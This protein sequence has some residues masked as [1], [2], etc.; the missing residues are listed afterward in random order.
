MT[1][2]RTLVW[3]LS[4]LFLFAQCSTTDN[5]TD[6]P[7][8]DNTQNEEPTP[9]EPVNEPSVEVELATIETTEITDISENSAK[10]GGAITDD[11][12]AEVTA[13]GVCWST[14]TEPSLENNVT[15]NGNGSG[16]FVAE[17]L[18]LTPNTTYYVRAYA[19]NSEGTAYG[20]E[21]TFTSLEV[22]DP[23]VVFQGDVLL[24][25]QEEVDDFGSQGYT[26][27]NGS[28]TIN[29]TNAPATILQ[30]DLLADLKIVDQGVSIVENDILADVT[31]LNNLEEVKSL[32]ISDN[33][34]LLQIGPFQSLRDLTGGDL[35]LSSANDETIVTG[36]ESLVDITLLNGLVFNSNT[37]NVIKELNAFNNL[38]SIQGGLGISRVLNLNAFS[39]LE[40]IS[41]GLTVFMMPNMEDFSFLSSITS[42]QALTVVENPELL[43][44]KGLENITN[45]GNSGFDVRNNAKLMNFEGLEGL[46]QIDGEF[47]VASNSQ[48]NSMSGLNS[49]VQIGT[50]RIGGNSLLTNVSGLSNLNFVLGNLIIENNAALLNLSGLENL[51]GIGTDLDIKNNDSLISLDGLTTLTT[52]LR[53]ITISDNAELINLDGLVNV[54]VLTPGSSV[55]EISDND[56]LIDLCGLLNITMNLS[57]SRIFIEGNKFNPTEQDI[58]NGDC[59]L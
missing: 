12:G 42:F 6:D 24:T 52:V 56:E 37:D 13:R 5:S 28:L 11:G 18:N 59:Q 26:R 51:E 29:D 41:R 17:L 25:S 19:T 40:S 21:L 43:N 2:I 54:S 36:F 20:N 39:N 16:I 50:L 55:V 27:V 47:L 53:D 45:I 9:V 31:G 14:E 32:V 35:Q 7:D 10:T 23:E 1:L 48:L 49:L 38:R 30:L 15:E 4:C 34:A 58:L 22:P 44:F 57:S 46:A 3:F 33:P 8:P